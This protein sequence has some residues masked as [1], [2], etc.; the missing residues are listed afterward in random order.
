MKKLKKITAIFLLALSTLNCSKA[1][2]TIVSFAGNSTPLCPTTNTA[3]QQL[4]NPLNTVA[5]PESLSGY[6]N[7]VIHEYTFKTSIAST[8]CSIGYQSQPNLSAQNYLIEIYDT[9]TSL[10][11]AT[12]NTTFS[13]MTTSYASLVTPL[14]LIANRDY[15]IKRYSPA[16]VANPNGLGRCV[17]NPVS[18]GGNVVFPKSNGNLTITASNFYTQNLNGIISAGVNSGLPYIDIVFQ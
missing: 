15:K 13:S 12:I 10:V 4:Y 17:S 11:V 1:D 3:F 6:A 14:I 5:M 8:I 9:T 18:G 7:S 16:T 2:E